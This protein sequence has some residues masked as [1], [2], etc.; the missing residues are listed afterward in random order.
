MTAGKHCVVLWLILS[1]A[2]CTPSSPTPPPTVTPSSSPSQGEANAAILLDDPRNDQQGRDASTKRHID[3]RSLDTK[4][5]GGRLRVR[6][7]LAAA[8][9]SSASLS[10]DEWISYLAYGFIGGRLAW[11]VRIEVV[12]VRSRR[13]EGEFT[14]ARTGSVDLFS[15]VIRGRVLTL[16][17]TSDAALSFDAVSAEAM[18]CVG[19]INNCR[20]EVRDEL[21]LKGISGG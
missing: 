6:W 19:V 9:P 16:V 11:V 7:T 20:R 15:P 14:N 1:L 10:K 8:P 5:S 21:P 12:P 17:A 13:W 18:W 2:A 3:V 4:L